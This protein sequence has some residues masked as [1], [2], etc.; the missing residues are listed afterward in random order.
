MLGLSH[1]R[2]NP[3]FPVL[4]KP[5]ERGLRSTYARCCDLHD[6]RGRF[7]NRNADQTL[8]TGLA[9]PRRIYLDEAVE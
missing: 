3:L 6:G 8:G 4:R 1:G 9:L 2:R 7:L 5:A